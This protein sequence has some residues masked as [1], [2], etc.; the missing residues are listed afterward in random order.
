MTCS[1]KIF[2]LF[3]AVF[4]LNFE[5]CFAPCARAE[6]EING[7]CCPMCAA[8]NHVYR[9]CTVDISTTCVRC[10][11]STYTDEPNGLIKCFSCIVCDSGQ[12]LRV[13]TSCTR[14]LNT[15]CEPLNGYYCT[16]QQGGS[17]RRAEKH[18]N[19]S[20]GQ[21]IKHRG[22]S[23]KDTE[24]AECAD[25]TFSNG[26]LQICQPHSKCEDLG[27]TEIKGGTL[28][29][30]AECGN[31][32]PAGVRAGIIVSI[33]I[34]AVA[35]LMLLRSKHKT[36]QL[37]ARDDET[38]RRQDI[39]LEEPNLGGVTTHQV[40]CGGTG[41]NVERGGGRK[42]GGWGLRVKTVCKGFS[43]T[44]CEPLDGYYCTD[45][46]SGSCRRAEKHTNCSTGQYIK[47]KDVKI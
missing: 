26:S 34:V 7:E 44:V 36:V 45:Q 33:L 22:T 37:A 8:G 9:H 29:S 2:I 3:A 23:F 27:L 24:C 4:F 41:C 30:D 32:T 39:E 11:E 5:L 15:V 25:G 28:S 10:P 43:D 31:K 20:P 17:C 13:K 12:S 21:Y 38:V 40:S 14:S 46:Y 16:D 1:F 19:C 47:Q 18:K 35:V 6:Y 42:C